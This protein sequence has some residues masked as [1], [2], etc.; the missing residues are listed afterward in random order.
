MRNLRLIVSALIVVHFCSASVDAHNSELARQ[1]ELQFDLNPDA[2]GF[3]E[4]RSRL[5]LE[6]ATAEDPASIGTA[7]AATQLAS[8]L[9]YKGSLKESQ[10]LLQRALN[11]VK[12]RQPRDESIEAIILNAFGMLY[13]RLNDY[14]RARIF[15]KQAVDHIKRGSDRTDVRLAELL[16]N[17]AALDS[18]NG[19]YKSA[20]DSFRQVLHIIE[21]I[22]GTDDVACSSVL[23]NLGLIYIQRRNWRLAESVLLRAASITERALGSQH[24][25]LASIFN[26]L[27]VVNQERRNLDA[28][29][30]FFRRALDIRIAASGPADPALGRVYSHLADV[31]FAR[32]NYEES[33]LLYNQ[34]LQVQE[35]NGDVRG[36][37]FA[38]TLEG[39]A[40]V[41]RKLRSPAE[42]DQM[43]ARAKAIRA[44]LAYTIS[45]RR[46]NKP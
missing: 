24:R 45:I 31:V 13:W 29:E 1:F 19:D 46:V 11:I 44:D 36:I 35:K 10:Q 6:T 3:A 38:Q 23:Q 17:L 16:N 22:R 8:V 15:F 9:L 27:G 39:L 28:A 20:E 18:I 43:A 42:A 12:A 34:S 2:K 25:D 7:I 40:Q 37:D 5:A 26:N 4:A 21:R 33:R 30:S 32:G 14:K 41:L